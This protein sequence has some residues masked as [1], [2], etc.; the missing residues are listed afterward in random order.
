MFLSGSV[1]TLFSSAV[2]ERA[3][4]D[5]DASYA[6]P[7]SVLAAITLV[8]GGIGGQAGRVGGQCEGGFSL[9]SV[10]VT[11]Q[12]GVGSQPKLLEQKL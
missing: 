7:Q 2:G 6:F 11:T 12:S 1:P 8:G 10:A 9:C 3:G 5:M 4:F